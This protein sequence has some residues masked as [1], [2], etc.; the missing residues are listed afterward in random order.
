MET[1][2]SLQPATPQHVAADNPLGGKKA[3]TSSTGGSGQNAKE[4]TPV[5]CVMR[6]VNIVLINKAQLRQ[7]TEKANGKCSNFMHQVLKKRCRQNASDAKGRLDGRVEHHSDGKLN[8]HL[9][10]ATAPRIG[11][12]HPIIIINSGGRAEDRHA[13]AGSQKGQTKAP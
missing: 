1:F 8:R 6:K 7:D 9:K 4:Y 10:Y 2:L 5:G 13:D 12:Q 3:E 11:T